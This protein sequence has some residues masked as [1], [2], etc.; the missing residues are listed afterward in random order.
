MVLLPYL[1]LFS[2]IANTKEIQ[3]RIQII[4]DLNKIIEEADKENTKINNEIANL[5]NE[6]KGKKTLGNPNYTYK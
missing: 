6:L 2:A 1:M 4:E 5:C 3:K